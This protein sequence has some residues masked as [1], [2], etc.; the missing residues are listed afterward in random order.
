M[1][2]NNVPLIKSKSKQAFEHN[3]KAE[4]EAGKPKDQALAI[5]YSTKRQASKMKKTPLAEGGMIKGATFAPKSV[6]MLESEK[7]EKM[8]MYEPKEERQAELKEEQE[9]VSQVEPILE[10]PQEEDDTIHES[11]ADAVMARRRKMAQG[12]QIQIE[13]NEQEE[14]DH[15]FL[16]EDMSEILKENYDEP[17]DHIDMIRRKM[18]KAQ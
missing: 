9:K 10:M 11:L 13:Q 3:F 6:R 14:P 15:S 8:G 7:T 12:G 1:K 5:A 17:K 2:A 18:K 16:D 4:L